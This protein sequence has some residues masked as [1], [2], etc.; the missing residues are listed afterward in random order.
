[1]IQIA[2]ATDMFRDI[3][4]I[5]PSEPLIRT[6]FDIYLHENMLVY[7][8]RPWR[9]CFSRPWRR[10]IRK[11]GAR[12]TRFVRVGRLHATSRR[13]WTIRDER[14]GISHRVD[15]VA[16]NTR[17]HGVYAHWMEPLQRLSNVVPT[18]ETVG[19]YTF[20]IVLPGNNEDVVGEVGLGDRGMWRC[21]KAN[22]PVFLVLPLFVLATQRNVRRNQ[23][24]L[25]QGVKT[26]APSARAAHSVESP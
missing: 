3:K 7:C 16:P 18:L 23:V 24:R 20:P 10:S 4:P 19:E 15:S 8:A 22:G 1:M 6:T 12:T 11:T 25:R 2:A 17:M 5:L 13:R 9:T 21:A 26:R 14:F